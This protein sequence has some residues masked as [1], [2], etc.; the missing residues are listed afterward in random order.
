MKNDIQELYDSLY[1]KKTLQELH[2]TKLSELKEYDCLTLA[3]KLP[4]HCH[5]V[6]IIRKLNALG[7]LPSAENAISIYDIPISRKMRNIFLRNGIVYLSQLS[8]YPREEILQFRTVGKNA[9]LEIDNLCE[10]Y[11]IQN[12]PSPP[13]KKHLANFHFTK[14]CTRYSLEAAYLV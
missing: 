13:L 7:Y 5:K 3:N 9:M 6:M 1:I 11:G 10:K 14:K 4:T 12:V 2:I 8:T